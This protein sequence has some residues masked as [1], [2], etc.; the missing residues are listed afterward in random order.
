MPQAKRFTALLGNQE[1]LQVAKSPCL[2]KLLH[3]Q[4]FWQLRDTLLLSA[5]Q[6]IFTQQQL[7]AELWELQWFN[8]HQDLSIDNILSLYHVNLPCFSC[9]NLPFLWTA[10]WTG[11]AS[12][13]TDRLGWR[14]PPSCLQP[15]LLP[16]EVSR[17]AQPETVPVRD[18]CSLPCFTYSFI[19]LLF[20]AKTCFLIYRKIGGSC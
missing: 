15:R 8:N 5:E 6:L 18:L 9:P 4:N 3:R 1:S 19:P 14:F 7:P 17:P 13:H 11:K 20:L 12:C 2:N 10:C 16:W